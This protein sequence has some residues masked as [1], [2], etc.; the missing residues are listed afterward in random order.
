MLSDIEV[1]SQGVPKLTEELIDRA[2]R[3]VL[4]S[5]WLQSFPEGD[6][7]EIG[8][9]LFD[10]LGLRKVDQDPTRTNHRVTSAPMPST[11]L[12]KLVDD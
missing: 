12:G 1:V 3:N 8:K 10:I 9:E 6:Q 2:R 11:T 4:G 7:A 5:T